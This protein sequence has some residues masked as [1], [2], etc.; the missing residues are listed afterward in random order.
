MS[1]HKDDKHNWLSF[2][3]WYGTKTKQSDTRK[4]LCDDVVK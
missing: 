3:V 4:C 1:G 2:S